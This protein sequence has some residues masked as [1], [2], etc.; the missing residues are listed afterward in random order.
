M[1]EKAGPSPPRSPGALAAALVEAREYTK[2]LYAHLTPAQRRF[3][4][5]PTVNPADW[6]LGHVGWFQEYWCVRTQRDDPGGARTPSRLAAA[7]A[8]WNSSTVPH[9]TR[10]SLPLPDWNGVH[11][12]LDATLADTLAALARSRDGERYFFELAL[13]HEDM[14]AEA[15]L[16]TL[17][18]LALPL[19]P[20]ARH[21]DE[22]PLDVAPAGAAPA[23]SDMPF[24]GGRLH[25]G[26]Q[27]ESA[28]SRFVF[29]NEKW[30]H[31][32]DVAPFLMASA[33]VTNAQFA[34]FVDGGGYQARDLWTAAGWA[35]LRHSA[36]MHP[37]HWQRAPTG[38]SQR[39]FD[40]WRALE[41]ALP[42]MHVNAHEAEAYCRFA[43]RRL[44]TE[45]EWEFAATNT[46]TTGV[47]RLDHG[48]FGPAA[49]GGATRMAHLLGNVWEWTATAFMPYPGFAPDPY[50]DYSAPWFG[51]H[52]VLRGG[53]FATRSRLVHAGFRNF[54]QPERSDPFVGFRTCALQH[55]V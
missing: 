32:V 2:S 28:A 50:A 17:Q 13:Y 5:G 21:A 1:S 53:S 14:H 54:Y 40:Q 30:A 31:P 20:G 52:R 25:L 24:A 7:D 11:A 35:S 43:G 55:D 34:A 41:P 29:D 8:L 15:L 48:R 38:W 23:A 49:S 18:A 39:H 3:P 9:A 19:P 12:Y 22:A 37:Q 33:C 47:A 6:E 42:V 51:N 36:A 27:P 16:M 44:P 26:A 45:A 4:F 10:W 46:P